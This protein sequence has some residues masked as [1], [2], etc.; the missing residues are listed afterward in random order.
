MVDRQLKPCDIKFIFYR[1]NS[2]QLYSQNK[3]LIFVLLCSFFC[4]VSFQT[5]LSHSHR[6]KI[7]YN[8]SSPFFQTR[9][10]PHWRPGHSS[11][12]Q[13]CQHSA[14]SDKKAQ[15]MQQAS[16]RPAL[17]YNLVAR[18]LHKSLIQSRPKLNVL[19]TCM[20]S[21]EQNKYLQFSEQRALG[22]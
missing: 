1:E 18:G 4:T 11:K 10:R 9:K 21:Y 3:N 20:F 15:G 19:H 7:L 17:L 8:T 16:K 2:F 12:L 5:S 13:L 6:V 14:D 22:N